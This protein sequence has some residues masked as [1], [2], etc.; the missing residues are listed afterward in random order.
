MIVMSDQNK[1]LSLNWFNKDKT[2][3]WDVST[4]AP[5]WVSINHIKVNEPRIFVDEK[6]IQGSNLDSFSK[7]KS[8]KKYSILKD[9]N[10]FFYLDFSNGDIYPFLNSMLNFDLIT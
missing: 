6:I 2:L 9:M 3:V 4:D 8:P 5:H 7:S 10:L 1:K